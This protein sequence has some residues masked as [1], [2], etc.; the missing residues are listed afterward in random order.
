MNAG[1]DLP[2]LQQVRYAGNQPARQQVEAV[3]KR[4]QQAAV[5]GEHGQLCAERARLNN[6]RKDRKDAGEQGKKNPKK[7]AAEATKGTK[8]AKKDTGKGPGEG[9]NGKGKGKGKGGGGSRSAPARAARRK[10]A[11]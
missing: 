8:A 11:P 1:E 7:A 3:Q 4:R 2:V 9:Q 5:N 10:N 6:V